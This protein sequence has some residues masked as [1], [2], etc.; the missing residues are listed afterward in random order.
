MFGYIA[1][2][3]PPEQKRYL[4]DRKNVYTK[5]LYHVDELGR[6]RNTFNWPYDFCSL[7]ESAKITT[8]VGFRPELD[9][10]V[11]EFDESKVTTLKSKAPQP[12]VDIDDINSDNILLP[13]LNMMQN[14]V[15]APPPMAP[16]A[17]PAGQ[18]LLATPAIAT[19]IIPVLHRS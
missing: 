12:N 11:E 18:E 1:D 17:P 16:P 9:R 3:L 4:E 2:D 6:G 14:M 15:F 7:I 13:N 19:P 10:E 5:G 8:K